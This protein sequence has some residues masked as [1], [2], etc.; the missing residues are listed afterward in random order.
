VLTHGTVEEVR[1]VARKAL[2][3]GVNVLEPCCGLEALM[4]LDNIK[5]LVEEAN[6]FKLGG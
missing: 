6:N 5:A 2:E 4:P 3:D 1:A